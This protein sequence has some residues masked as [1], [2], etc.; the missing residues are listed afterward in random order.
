MKKVS[1]IKQVFHAINKGLMELPSMNLNERNKTIQHLILI[2][3]ELCDNVV[4]LI[5]KYDEARK[6]LSEA[7]RTM[8]GV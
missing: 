1:D 3:E 4:N 6:E 8:Q 5:K 2:N 7:S